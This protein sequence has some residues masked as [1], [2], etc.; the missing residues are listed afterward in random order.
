MKTILYTIPHSGRNDSSGEKKKEDFL[1]CPSLLI[2]TSHRSLSFG[3]SEVS[4]LDGDV[5]L[6]PLS[7]ALFEIGRK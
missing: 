1:D 6:N 7:L 5:T 3:I 4:C 2:F